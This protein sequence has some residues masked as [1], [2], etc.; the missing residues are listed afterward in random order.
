MVN[1]DEAQSVLVGSLRTEPD[2]L[3]FSFVRSG[4]IS[5]VIILDLF[6]VGAPCMGENGVGGISSPLRSTKLGSPLSLNFKKRILWKQMAQVVSREMP[7]GGRWLACGGNGGATRRRQGTDE[8]CIPGHYSLDFQIQLSKRGTI[9]TTVRD[10][11]PKKR[12]W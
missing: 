2:L 3:V 4:S 11:D 5:K 10:R 7:A 6:A 12:S 1:P 8:A 9:S